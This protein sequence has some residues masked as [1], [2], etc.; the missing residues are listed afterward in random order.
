MK[1]FVGAA[2]SCHYKAKNLSVRPENTAFDFVTAF[3]EQVHH[4][5][6]ILFGIARQARHAGQ[7]GVGEL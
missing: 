1:G 2:V 6:C 3:M 4:V 7:L 5:R